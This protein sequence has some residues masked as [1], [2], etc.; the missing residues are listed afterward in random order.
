MAVMNRPDRLECFSCAGFCFTLTGGMMS[1]ILFLFIF[2]LS[3]AI[4]K[5]DGGSM[6]HGMGFF[7]IMIGWRLLSI[8]E[9]QP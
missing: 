7:I 5:G 4:N 3:F 6:L 8:R 2:S 1:N 9:A